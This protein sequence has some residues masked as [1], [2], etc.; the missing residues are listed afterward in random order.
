MNVLLID[1][2]DSFTFN[3]VQQLQGLGAE[4]VVH[5]NDRIDLP[6]IRALGP[7]HVVLSPGPGRPDHPRDFG[8]CR[9][10]IDHLTH[11]PIL[12]VCLGHQGIGWRMGGQ[13]V[14]APTIVHGKT[15]RITHSGIGL[16][17]GLPHPLTVM[18]YHSLVVDRASLPDSL[19][20]TAE[21]AD[22]LIMAMRHRTRPLFGVQFHPESIGTPDGDALLRNFLAIRGAA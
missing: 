3:L 1:N 19:V 12:G 13:V 15:D 17:A 14:A 7:T 5:R 10:I 9:P 21:N 6:A 16:F 8:V 2:Y 11:T 20:V 18:R 4:V 22:G